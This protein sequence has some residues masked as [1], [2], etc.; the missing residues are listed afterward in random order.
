MVGMLHELLEPSVGDGD[1]LAFGVVVTNF[2]AFVGGLLDDVLHV[3]LPQS[4]QYTK[5]ELA[6]RQLVGE[7]LLGGEILRQHFIFQSILIEV[8]HRELLIC[9]DIET[10]DLVLLEMQLLVGEDVS[11]K[12]E[13]GALHRGQEH[14]HYIHVRMR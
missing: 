5:E 13:L 4:T 11:H 10:D 14:V 2:V 9:R 1:A 12:T 7:L 3:L 8:L 6:L